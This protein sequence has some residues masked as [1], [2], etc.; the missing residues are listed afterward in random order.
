MQSSS[1]LD[2][3]ATY[4]ELAGIWR[5]LNAASAVLD[6]EIVV[7]GD[8]GRPSFEGLQR[9]DSQVV[10]Q[11]FD[12]LEIDGNDVTGLA[13]EQ[14][15]DLLAKVLDAGDNWTVPGTSHRRGSGT[16]GSYCRAGARR[17]DGQTAGQRLR[18]GQAQPELA[19][20]EE[21][22]LDGGRDRRLHPGERQ[23]Q[24]HLRRTARRQTRRR[25][26]SASPEASVPGSHSAGSR[27]CVR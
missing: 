8:D 10:F 19:Q 7:F 24:R 11:A 15:R 13:Y 20:G 16:A 3:T 17:G 12:V 4:P 22:D 25:P 14:R 21:P 6:G 9:H 26:C 2:V 5:D 27:N 1:G 18:G 23:P